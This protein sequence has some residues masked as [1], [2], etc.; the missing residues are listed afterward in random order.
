MYAVGMYS[1]AAAVWRW[2][3]LGA[4]TASGPT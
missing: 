2:W 1:T 3:W 4:A